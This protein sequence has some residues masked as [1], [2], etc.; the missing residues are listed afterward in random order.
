MSGRFFCFGGVLEKKQA[1]ER[2]PSNDRHT[3]QDKL[4]TVA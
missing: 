4:K 2:S 3:K 1:D